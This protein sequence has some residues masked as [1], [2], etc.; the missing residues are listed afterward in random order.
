MSSRKN[1]AEVKQQDI[2][3]FLDEDERA[4]CFILILPGPEFYLKLSQ[5]FTFQFCEVFQLSILELGHLEN[6]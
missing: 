2:L 1:R 6:G 5:P 3:N 4:V